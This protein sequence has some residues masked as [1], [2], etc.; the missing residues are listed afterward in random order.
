MSNAMPGELWWGFWSDYPKVNHNG[1]LYA[2]IGERL[3]TE[4]AVERFLPSGR[5]TIG[6]VPI[7]D[8]EGGGHTY[9]RAARSISPFY[10]ELAITNG[11]KKWIVEKTELRTIHRF[12]DLEVV[13]TRDDSVVITVGYHHG[14]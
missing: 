3:Y 9:H 11:S 8:R 2:K 1:R 12:G 13:T 5:R 6:N 10:V 4:H 7:S 14:S